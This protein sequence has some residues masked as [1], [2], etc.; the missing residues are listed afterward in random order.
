M[1]VGL[2]SLGG[3]SAGAA[4]AVDGPLTGLVIAIDPG[5]QLGNSNPKF[6]QQM[7]Q[8]NSMERS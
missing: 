5:H 2:L 3:L 7:K 8:K 4:P 1:T 6:A